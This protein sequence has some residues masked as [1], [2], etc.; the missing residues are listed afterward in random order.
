MS[1]FETDLATLMD[2]FRPPFYPEVPV[3]GQARN[4]TA[5]GIITKDVIEVEVTLL[6]TKGRRMSQW[7]RVPCALKDR[8]QTTTRVDG[9]WIRHVLWNAYAPDG[10]NLFHV[11]NSKSSLNLPR[12]C[13]DA[14]RLAAITS[15]PLQPPTNPTSKRPGPPAQD[16][17][18]AG[19]KAMPRA[20]P[21]APT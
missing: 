3:L 8:G 20:A 18:Y 21:R 13:P 4:Q 15:A 6:D 1:L 9:P 5:N 14:K 10:K 11:A 16:L 2:P 7:L 12:R 17:M 19:P